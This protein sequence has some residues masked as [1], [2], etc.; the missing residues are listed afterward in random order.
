MGYREGLK[1]AL[2]SGYTSVMVE[3]DSEAVVKVFSQDPANSLLMD[4]LIVD[5]NFLIRQL[6][7]F[8]LQHVLREDNQCADFLAN[9]GQS[10]PWG[11]TILETPPVDLANLLDHDAKDVSFRRIR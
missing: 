9:Q 10:S 2:S 4:T 8:K 6:Q 7:D 5:C 1:L 3:T 11:T